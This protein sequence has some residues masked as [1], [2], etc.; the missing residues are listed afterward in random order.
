[1]GSNRGLRDKHVQMLHLTPPSPL[2][3]SN[4]LINL[5][6]LSAFHPNVPSLRLS[7]MFRPPSQAREAKPRPFY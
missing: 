7:G 5:H 2:H 6:R 1:M 3:Y 4:N